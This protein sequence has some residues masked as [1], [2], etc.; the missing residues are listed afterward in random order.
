MIV[1]GVSHPT[2]GSVPMV[3][4]DGQSFLSRDSI[5]E[6]AVKVDV[7]EINRVGKDEGGRFTFWYVH[8]FTGAGSN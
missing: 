2:D 3:K 1:G 6:G 7:L 8:G 5:D 4:V